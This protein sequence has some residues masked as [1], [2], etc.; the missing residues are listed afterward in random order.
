MK[1]QITQKDIDTMILALEKQKAALP[2]FNIFGND[3]HLIIDTQIEIL[4][5]KI[6][7]EDAI[8]DREEEFGDS[9]SDVVQ[10]FDFLKGWDV[11][12]VD[13]E[14]LEA[15]KLEGPKPKSIV[16]AKACA[17]CPFSNR[18]MKGWLSNYT[19]DDVKQFIFNEA[20][21][22]CHMM[23]PENDMT[24]EEVQEA[25][26]KGE[27][28]FCRGYVESMIKSAKRPKYNQELLEAYKK[29]REEGLSDHTMDIM[30]FEKHHTLTKK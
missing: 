28:K 15:A 22:P 26:K 3:N 19:I 27:I 25:I 11:E 21:F 18:S 16:C 13:E 20:F 4:Q 12:L 7:S 30:E 10:A 1:K 17:E 24:Q 8:W 14:H 2:R 29:V 6:T 9:T 23:M 5:K